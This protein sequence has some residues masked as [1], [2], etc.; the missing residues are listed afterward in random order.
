MITHR[1]RVTVSVKCQVL[2]LVLVLIVYVDVVTVA[3]STRT[4]S[5]V[6][7]MCSMR[8]HDTCSVCSIYMRLDLD[9]IH[10]SRK[11]MFFSKTQ[12]L[13]RAILFDVQQHVK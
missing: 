9:I 7:H 6:N 8:A 2:V 12:L 1:V 3:T 10:L 13:A 4:V 5:R 11:R